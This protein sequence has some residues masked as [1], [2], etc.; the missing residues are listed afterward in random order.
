MKPV[1]AHVASSSGMNPKAEVL[2]K[3][4]HDFFI[5]VIRFCDTIPESAAG[6]SISSQLL[7]SAG[8]VDSNYGA[9]CKGRTRKQF[10]D[11]VGIAAEEAD[12]SKRWL[13]A[14][15]DAN[16]G[17]KDEVV[18]LIKEANELTAILVASHKTARAGQEETERREAAARAARRNRKSPIR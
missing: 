10:I 12:E 2:K 4:T 16:L 5:R 13:E 3:R 17:E 8:S 6:A 7:D 11:K 18:K 1:G 9:A 14:L 15:R